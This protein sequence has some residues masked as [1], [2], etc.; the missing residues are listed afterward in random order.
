MKFFKDPNEPWGVREFLILIVAIALQIYDLSIR[1]SGT[2]YP[3]I[4]PSLISL[5]FAMALIAT[6]FLDKK[7]P[8]FLDDFFNK[9]HISSPGIRKLFTYLSFSFFAYIIPF[10]NY[11]FVKVPESYGSIPLRL[12]TSTILIFWPIWIIFIAYQEPKFLTRIG[13]T[14]YML[15][16]VIILIASTVPMAEHELQNFDIPGVMPGQTIGTLYKTVSDGISRMWSWPGK[17]KGSISLLE[18]EIRASIEYSKTGVDPR[19]AKVDESKTRNPGVEVLELQSTS[20]RYYIEDQV[21]VYAKIRAETLAEPVEVTVD[22]MATSD[23][24]PGNIFPQSTFTIEGS[25]VIDIDC[26]FP[27]G[28]LDAGMHT[29]TLTTNFNFETVS[30]IETF[31]MEEG[32]LRQMQSQ[33]KDPLKDYPPAEATSSKG[34]VN[35]NIA[36][37]EAPI[38]SKPNQ[39]ITASI[40]VHN[41]GKGKIKSINDLFIFIPKGLELATEIDSTG[42]FEQI[43]CD[44]LPFE[45]AKFCKPQAVN[46][47]KVS[48]IE[49]DKASYQDIRTKKTFRMY[50]NTEDYDTLMGRA[51]IKPG[52]FYSSIKYNYELETTTPIRVEEFIST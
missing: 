18:Q 3:P 8:G 34:P 39:K 41:S 47:Y 37:P 19:R 50:L 44:V 23:P 43:T 6:F 33:R 27:Q 9:I 12:I 10:I 42:V 7:P 52:S 26:I 46:V 31:F 15:I 48:S 11:L 28:E 14:V 22:C 32:K 21:T 1:L 51:S 25:D 45:E 13:G 5:Y 38:S 24:V 30:Y 29:V 35:I 17:A 36:I 49:L 20:P 16:W 2:N 4:I 40:T